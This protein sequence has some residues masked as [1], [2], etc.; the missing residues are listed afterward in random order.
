MTAAERTA[1]K[2]TM[3][4]HGIVKMVTHDQACAI[5]ARACTC[6]RPPIEIGGVSFGSHA[7]TCAKLASAEC[8]CTPDVIV[9]DDA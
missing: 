9:A 1:A 8:T 5:V 7:P 2:A 6:A 4:T 3:R